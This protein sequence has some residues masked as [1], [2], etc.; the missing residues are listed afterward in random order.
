MA[1]K[2]K[3]FLAG[4][5]TR[6]ASASDEDFEAAIGLNRLESPTNSPSIQSR[7]IPI[8]RIRPNP[9]QA[10]RNFDG[11]E[12]LA[13]VIR[14]QGFVSRLR[15]RP[16][17]TAEDYFQLVYGERRLRAAQMAGLSELPCD[18]VTYSDRQ[19]IEI[20]LAEN[21]QRQDLNP[22]EEARAF[23]QFM[24]EFD[25]SIRGLAERLGKHKDY[26]DGRLALLRAPSDV[27]EL[28]AQRPD[29]VTVARRIARLE[30]EA[31]RRPLIEAVLNGTLNK[32]DVRNIVQE[33]APVPNVE[34]A[35]Q[36]VSAN[37]REIVINGQAYSP[38]EN[39]DLLDDSPAPAVMP[40]KVRHD[41]QQPKAET[42]RKKL[43]VEEA[44]IVSMLGRWQAL[45]P[46]LDAD[47]RIFLEHSLGH[48]RAALERLE[49]G[50]ETL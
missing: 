30:N 24:L 15:V 46:T 20:G 12:E 42:F 31:E 45:L 38:A 1:A 9:F 16:D 17:P 5:A 49:A 32:E 27:Q 7:N 19:M 2:P 18:L 48:I 29:T 14:Q 44:K 6:P 34:D 26:V 40:K 11:L 50:K 23:Q 39:E 36:E 33:R 28:V 8:E 22:L 13:E 10:R 47:D 43:A 37:N 35:T 3:S 21:I 41:G 25:Y 4:R